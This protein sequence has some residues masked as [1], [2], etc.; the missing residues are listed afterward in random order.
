MPQDLE[1]LAEKEQAL[2]LGEGA[3][4]RQGRSESGRRLGLR[5]RKGES[6]SP[7]REGMTPVV[8]GRSANGQGS[9]QA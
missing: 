4:N 2:R 9:A 3:M 8:Y 6:S 1:D 7:D 5:G